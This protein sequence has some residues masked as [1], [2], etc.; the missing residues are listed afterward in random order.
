LILY[1]AD[2]ELTDSMITEFQLAGNS[3]AVA[4]MSIGQI[5]LDPIR[6]NVTTGLWGLKGLQGGLTIIK[7]VDVMGGTT[8]AITL[9]IDTGIYNPSS[10]V[11]ATGDLTLQLFRQSADLGTALLPNLSL[12]MGNN[13]VTTIGSFTPNNSPL[14]LQTLN[15]FVGGKDVNLDIAGYDQ[16]TNVASLLQAFET[17][18]ISVVLPGLNASLLSS[19]ALEGTYLSGRLCHSPQLTNIY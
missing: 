5:T 17:L 8:D 10:L 12:A 9:N 11:L 6:V 16:S 3:K 4:N 19:A 1:Y 14:G 15:E 18:N 13:T 2:A 7:S